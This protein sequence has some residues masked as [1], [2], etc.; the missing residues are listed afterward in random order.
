V[1]PDKTQKEKNMSVAAS[2]NHSAVTVPRQDRDSIRKF[3][4][5][6]LGGKIV[7]ED[8]ERDILCLE[9]NLY[10]AFLY[11]MSLMRASSYGLQDRSGWKSSPTTWKK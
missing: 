7:K 8:S 4:C 11:G 2:G 6:A 3:Y 1:K 9:E 10:I 5:D